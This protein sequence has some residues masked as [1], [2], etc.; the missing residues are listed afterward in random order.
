[1]GCLIWFKGN[2]A[3][4]E[5]G[6]SILKITVKSVLNKLATTQFPPRLY[7]ASCTHVFGGTMCGYDR[8]AGENALGASTG[9][10]QETITATSGST[11]YEV[12]STFIPGT[13]PSPY[14]EGTII[15]VTGA[16]AGASRTIVDHASGT[17][18]V[19]RPWLSTVTIGDTFNILPGCSHVDTYCDTVLNNLGRFGGFPRIPPPEASVAIALA[20]MS[21][22]AWL[23]GTVI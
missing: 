4:I 21:S 15:G 5:V 14:I 6:R 8:V 13:S 3:D 9:I 2:V 16:N 7:A 22:F 18:T 12:H 10:G 17:V 11:Q 20:A 23:L 19:K 1:L